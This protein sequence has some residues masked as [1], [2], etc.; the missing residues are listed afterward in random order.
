VHDNL[1]G[2]GFLGGDHDDES[3][4]FFERVSS[5]WG[6]CCPCYGGGGDVG[7]AFPGGECD[8]NSTFGD[9]IRSRNLRH[10]I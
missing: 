6:Y 1:D 7:G 4:C 2:V 10:G 3:G 5:R 9:R 8:D